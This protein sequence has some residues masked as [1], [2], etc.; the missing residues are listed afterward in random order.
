MEIAIGFCNLCKC[1]IYKSAQG[2]RCGCGRPLM[3]EPIKTFICCDCRKEFEDTQG[4]GRPKKRCKECI[5]NKRNDEAR[6]YQR[7]RR[8]GKKY[9]IL[10]SLL[11]T[12]EPKTR[13]KKQEIF[14]K[15]ISADIP[16][17]RRNLGERRSR[18]FE[19]KAAMVSAMDL[20]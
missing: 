6:E 10:K 2:V 8:G 13:E 9:L 14:K 19:A 1:N 20:D 3:K 18:I 7:K 5:I 11:K 4:R 16:G 17:H 12:N 15:A